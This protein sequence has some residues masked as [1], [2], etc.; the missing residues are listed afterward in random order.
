MQRGVSVQARGSGRTRLATRISTVP[1][2]VDLYFADQP[3]RR[4]L[5]SCIAFGCGYYSANTGAAPSSQGAQ[6]SCGHIP[7]SQRLM[8]MAASGQ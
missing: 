6:Y 5:W 3:L 4:V 2:R 8:Y 7:I 1:R